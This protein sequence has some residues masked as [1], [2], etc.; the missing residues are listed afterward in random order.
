MKQRRTALVNAGELAIR[1]LNQIGAVDVR[2]RAARSPVHGNAEFL[3]AGPP[4]AVI[5][6]R[7]LR[8]HE[9]VPQIGGSVPSR[10]FLKPQDG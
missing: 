8:L 9:A 3:F 6:S 2:K 5:G 7:P 10:D 4:R 1:D